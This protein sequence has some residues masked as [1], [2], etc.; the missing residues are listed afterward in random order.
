VSDLVV[1]TI[2][3]PMARNKTK[4]SYGT[5]ECEC[6]RLNGYKKE[7]VEYGGELECA[8]GAVV[9]FDLPVVRGE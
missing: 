7:L 5:Y 2:P 6:G 9:K 3:N 4:D 8:C 1:K